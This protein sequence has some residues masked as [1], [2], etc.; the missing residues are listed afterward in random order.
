[1]INERDGG[2]MMYRFLRG[3]LAAGCC[4][5]SVALAAGK[6]SVPDSAVI[7]EKNPFDREHRVWPDIVAPP[8]PPAPISTED[9]QLYGVVIAGSVKRAIVK[10]GGNLKHLAGPSGRAYLSVSEGQSL[11]AYVISEIQPHQVLLSAGATRQVVVFGKKMDR[12]LTPMMAMQ[13]PSSPPPSPAQVPSTPDAVPAAASLPSPATL[14]APTYTPPAAPAV[15][16]ASQ[17]QA[18]SLPAPASPA[19]DQA[20]GMTR[21]AG[22]QSGMSLAEAIAAAQAAAAQGNQPPAP[23]PFLM[24]K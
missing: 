23:N 24:R 5:A 22:S 8:T 12:P 1:M 2:G 21:P 18:A 16:A 9:L 6:S 14:P 10:V 3:L 19:Q 17:A 15:P 11:G 7:A 13:A 20:T 4:I